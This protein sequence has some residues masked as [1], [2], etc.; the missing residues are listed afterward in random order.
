MQGGAIRPPPSSFLQITR[1]N[2][3]LTPPPEISWLFLNNS[4][5]EFQQKKNSKPFLKV[6]KNDRKKSRRI[7][8]CLL[9]KLSEILHIRWRFFLLFDEILKIRILEPKNAFWKGAKK[10]EVKKSSNQKISFTKVVGNFTH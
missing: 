9:Q 5:T 8:K 1:K 7:K 3:K 6:S 2:L 4:C 10:H